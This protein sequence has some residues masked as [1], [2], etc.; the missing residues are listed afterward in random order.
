[1]KTRNRMPL[2]YTQIKFYEIDPKI[3][4]STPKFLKKNN[5]DILA[6]N[7]RHLHWWFNQNRYA[8]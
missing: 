7:F 1:M 4:S 6:S 5:N 2:T 3:L 8:L